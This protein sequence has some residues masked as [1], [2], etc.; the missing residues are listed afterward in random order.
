MAA[1]INLVKKIAQI[2][3][4]FFLEHDD[5]IFRGIT[6]IDS[7][8]TN[9]DLSIKLFFKHMFLRGRRDSVSMKFYSDFE[10]QFVAYFGNDDEVNG[11]GFAGKL[12]DID[13]QAYDEA[14]KT[15][16]VNNGADRKMILSSYR[17]FA[18]LPDNNPTNYIL[19]NPIE[20]TYKRIDDIDSIGDKLTSFYHRNLYKRFDIPEN[21]NGNEN[22]LLPIDTHIGKIS[23]LAG[24]TSEIENKT[25]REKIA[26]KYLQAIS[27]YSFDNKGEITKVNLNRDDLNEIKQAIIITCAKYSINPMDYNQGAWCV[28]F[29]SLPILFSL[30]EISDMKRIKFSFN[31][32]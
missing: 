25:I 5:T 6:D 10:R 18:E 19:N 28:G 9:R 24:I 31:L 3:A 11:A 16:G 7:L 29:Y 1:N 15:S 20:Q 26:A 13:P 32:I 8:L 14:L 4:K 2:G 12:K 22:F 17:F 30:L 27:D 21:V 23:F